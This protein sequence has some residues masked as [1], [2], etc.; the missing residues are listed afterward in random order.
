[1]K[2][3]FGIRKQRVF[4]K[5]GKW[6]RDT[7]EPS[8]RKFLNEAFIFYGRPGKRSPGKSKSLRV[9]EKTPHKP[10]NDESIT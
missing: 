3:K 5:Q 1:V 4:G 8:E 6:S 7:D 9:E 10:Q 2:N